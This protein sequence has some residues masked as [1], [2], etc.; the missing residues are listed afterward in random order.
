MNDLGNLSHVGQSGAFED[1]NFES[2]RMTAGCPARI[3]LSREEKSACC[4]CSAEMLTLTGMSR[5]AAFQVS[6][7]RS[8]SR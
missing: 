8:T 7:C 1:L 5:P 4:N 2:R 6:I 3:A